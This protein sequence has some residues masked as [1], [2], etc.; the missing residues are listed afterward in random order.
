MS[1]LRDYQPLHLEA[2][3]DRGLSLVSASLQ[4]AV[5]KVG[6]FAYLPEKRRFAFV[7]N[8]FVWECAFDRKHGPF[9]RVRT[10]VH[11]DDVLGVKHQNIRLDRKSAIVNLL[12]I[13][14]VPGEDGTGEILLEFAGGGVIGLDVEAINISSSDLSEPWRTRSKP[15]HH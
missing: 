8:R 2:S 1:S 13:R 14:F 10:G 6:D 15:E 9:A 11:F 5:A 3:D 12:A 7:V 4:D